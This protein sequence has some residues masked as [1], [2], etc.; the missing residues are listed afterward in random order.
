MIIVGW[1]VM[2]G[3][4]CVSMLISRLV[5]VNGA[6]PLEARALCWVLWLAMPA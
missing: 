1:A 6:H 4:A 5:V 2:A 3:V